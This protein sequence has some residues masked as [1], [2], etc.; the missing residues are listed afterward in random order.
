MHVLVFYFLVPSAFIYLF[1][2]TSKRAYITFVIS[3]LSIR[4]YV[5]LKK[6]KGKLRD[7]PLEFCMTGKQEFTFLQTP[8]TA[9]VN[10]LHWGGGGG[11]Y[12]STLSKKKER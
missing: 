9:N 7:I 5:H 3:K 1:L 2:F 12:L 8:H 10:M 4:F 11:S 6:E